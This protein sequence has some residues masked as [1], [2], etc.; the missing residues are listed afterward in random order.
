MA[1]MRDL[2]SMSSNIFPGHP[3]FI[4]DALNYV[5]DHYNERYVMISSN[6]LSKMPRDLQ[7]KA[8]LFRY[9]YGK[10]C[11]LWLK[12]APKERDL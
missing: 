6:P 10:Y 2:R 4:I 11:P 9:R 3:N 7:M 1:E 12:P 5:Q 8:L